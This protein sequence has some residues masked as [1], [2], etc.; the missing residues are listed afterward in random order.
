[1]AKYWLGTIVGIAVLSLALGL[2]TNGP[3]AGAEVDN[4][5]AISCL[6]LA[7]PIDGDGD[8]PV[9]A[10][11][12]NA[13]CDGLT[14]ADV[15]LIAAAVGDADGVL[16][17]GELAAL[18]LDANQ[19][20][21]PG[22]APL[23]SIYIIALV[24]DDELV[25][26]DADFGGSVT[27]NDDGALGEATPGDDAN[28]E[29]C[30]GD[31]DADCG[32]E[33]FGN[34]D[35]VV[36]A[37]IRAV[38]ASD[39]TNI[40]V[41]VTQEGVSE[42]QTLLVVGS[43]F[44]V[45]LN[46]VETT[47][48]SGSSTEC[49]D[50]TLDVFD[51]AAIGDAASTLARAVIVDND[52]RALTRIV[53]DF[54]SADANIAIVGDTSELSV[55]GGTRGM[56]A[57]AVICGGDVAGATTITADIGADDDS[58]PITVVAATPGITLT[59][60]PAQ[61]ECDGVASSTLTATVFDESGQRVPDGTNVNFSVVALGSAD[62]VNALTTGGVAA[63]IITPLAGAS[64]VT[65]IV[66]AGAAQ[67]QIRIECGGQTE[68][69]A[70]RAIE[71]KATPPLITC[72]ANHAST[73][74]VRLRDDNDQPI[75]DGTYVEFSVEN[76]G[77]N[78]GYRFSQDQAVTSGG[79]VT[80]DVFFQS[81]DPLPP[82]AFDV[83]ATSGMISGTIR[84]RCDGVLCMSPPPHPMSPPCV[85]PP[86]SPPGCVEEPTSP[87]ESVSPPCPTAT[88]FPPSPPP[89]EWPFSPPNCDPGEL[90]SPSST[91]TPADTATARST[92]TKQPPRTPRATRTP[93]PTKTPRAH[94]C[95]D[96]TGDGAVS[97]A[98]L[99]AISAKA[100]R[101]YD[102]RYDINDDGKVTFRDV[103]AAAAQL[104]RRC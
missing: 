26:F 50:G 7:G 46:L 87:P 54:S 99:V 27:I 22:S 41:A 84:V 59:A 36:V 65:V 19:I 78:Y 23:D 69:G 5:V 68:F 42:T 82:S 64:G 75:A 101:G 104:K 88:P 9:G 15:G 16:E 45:D 34:G 103:L 96:V 58:L 24:D 21:V 72:D 71:L 4:T 92:R 95:A 51:D 52:D 56:G 32:T 28:V 80:T 14:A 49:R 98:D 89:C 25:T 39:G 10:A 53:A 67:A 43:P 60:S 1:M 57:F 55:D 61:V 66:T 77:D 31:D 20:T 94:A 40:D 62:P 86:P 73:I 47:V 85:Q 33:I 79:E 90:A 74:R 17:P 2:V 30:E 102:A 38:T 18:D 13:A 37:T 76:A 63:S 83:R 91:A 29:T 6:F 93:K 44:R 11:D 12:A 3:R 8:D 48:F 97:S 35:G 70:P 100:G 81:V